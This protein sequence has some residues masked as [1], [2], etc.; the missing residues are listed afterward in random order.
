MTDPETSTAAELR[1]DN[2]ALR[3]CIVRARNRLAVLM[4]L[5]HPQVLLAG[6][7]DAIAIL[8]R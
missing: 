6:I 7:R 2:D 5:Q 1:L 3:A 4:V 8:L